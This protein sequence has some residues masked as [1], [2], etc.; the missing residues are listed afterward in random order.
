MDRGKA[1]AGKRIRADNLIQWEFPRLCSAVLLDQGADN[2]LG[3]A[4]MGRGGVDL[5]LLPLPLPGG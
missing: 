1:E 2:H 5:T 3:A 4:L